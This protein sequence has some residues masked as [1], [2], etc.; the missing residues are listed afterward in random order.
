MMSPADHDDRAE[1]RTQPS[2]AADHRHIVRLVERL[3]AAKD[4]PD[5]SGILDVIAGLL[6]EHFAEE[7]GPDG[8]FAELRAQRPEFTHRVDRVEAAHERILGSIAELRELVA[9][10]ER[11]LA[12]MR[13]AKAALAQQIRSHERQENKLMADTYLMD[14]GESG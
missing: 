6:P 13:E 8:F 12:K 14:L 3:E 10:A 9:Q 1:T 2:S 11:A 4:L 7:E 5:V